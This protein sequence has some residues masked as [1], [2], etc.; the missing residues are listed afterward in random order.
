MLCWIVKKKIKDFQKMWN[1]P[2]MWGSLVS[3]EKSKSKKSHA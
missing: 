2:G 3:Q 1:C